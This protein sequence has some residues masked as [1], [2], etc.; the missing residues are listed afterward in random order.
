V[1]IRRNRPGIILLFFLSIT[2]S[3]CGGGGGPEAVS[4]PPQTGGA[5]PDAGGPDSGGDADDDDSQADG[6]E[7]GEDSGEDSGGDAGE[8]PDTGPDLSKAGSAPDLDVWISSGFL[9][10]D[11]DGDG[12]E[13]ASDPRPDAGP[14]YADPVSARSL[15]IERAWSDVEGYTVED[16]AREGSVLNLRVRGI[17]LDDA[18]PVW[19]AFR[20]GDGLRAAKAE[21]IANGLLEVIPA[22]GAT[23]AHV[24]A[25]SVRGP[26][27]EMQ[28]LQRTAPLLFPVEGTVIA[29]SQIE[30]QGL[31]LDHITAVALAGE[32]LQIGERSSRGITVRLPETGQGNRVVARSATT[33]SNGIEMDLRHEVT[34][35]VAPELALA[36]GESLLFWTEGRQHRLRHGEEL[37]L[38]AP[39]WKPLSLT[40][41]IAA[42]DTVRS[43]GRLKAT[44]LPGAGSLEVSARSTLLARLVALRDNLLDSDPGTWQGIR[45]A[46]EPALTTAAASDYLGTLA[47]HA[48]GRGPAPDDRLVNAVIQAWQPSADRATA[49]AKAGDAPTN[50]SSAKPTTSW[51]GDLDDIVTSTVTY[52]GEGPIDKDEAGTEAGERYPDETETIGNAYSQIIILQHGDDTLERLS[53]TGPQGCDYSPDENGWASLRNQSADVYRRLWRSDLCIQ[54]DGLVFASAAV[55]QPAFG[56]A[57]QIFDQAASASGPD[58]LPDEM[59]RRHTRPT[60]ADS[61]YQLK[62]GG[63]YLKSDDNSPLCHMEQCYIEVITSGYGAYY[64]VSLTPSQQ[65]IVKFLRQRMWVER[66][67]PWMLG[68]AGIGVDE[69][70]VNCLRDDLLDSREFTDAAD[71]LFARIRRD[72]DKILANPLDELADAIDATL[73]PWARKY[74]K[75]ELGTDFID[76]AVKSADAVAAGVIE[77]RI[78]DKL[79]ELPGLALFSEIFSF[80]RNLGSAVLT[81]EKFV[82]RVQPVAEITGITPKTI[83]LYESD[84]SLGILGDWLAQTDPNASTPC[85]GDGW[86]PELVVRD[87]FGQ[88]AVVPLDETN[89]E[90]GPSACGPVCKILEIP[91]SQLASPLQELASG[92]IR[93]EL[94]VADGSFLSYPGGKLRIPV[95]GDEMRL[96]TKAKIIGFSKPLAKPGEQLTIIGSN[97]GVF[98]DLADWRLERD[99]GFGGDFGLDVIEPASG[100]D[101]GP[102]VRLPAGIPEGDYKVVVEPDADAQISESLTGDTV[103]L[104]VGQPLPFIAAAD[105]GITR[106]DRMRIELLDSSGSVVMAERPLRQLAWDLPTNEVNPVGPGKYVFGEAWNDLPGEDGEPALVSAKVQRVRVTCAGSGSDGACTYAIRSLRDGFCLSRDSEP[107]PAVAGKLE[108]GQDETY[109]LAV[110]LYDFDGTSLGQ[111]TCQEAF[112]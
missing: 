90:P 77:E 48:A 53:W 82:F 9:V 25:G 1:M 15:F 72:E 111:Q 112:L 56:E 110:V 71:D 75:G 18:T 50:A 95:P 7:A 99:D 8:D 101:T 17:A 16:V 6:G 51:N 104:V 49:T 96:S 109:R 108:E 102:T 83:D 54:I 22:P 55:V 41:D 87:R 106:D 23:Q 45:A 70:V 29:G 47:E 69:N 4:T 92:P 10:S 63:Y 68:L 43:S 13:D 105:Q 79:P 84:E 24:I 14:V 61:E 2:L 66:L 32:P 81:P 3:A 42:G 39:A 97:L 57:R 19:V 5:P 107:I 73:G 26:A 20:T 46:L 35:R 78:S 62:E 58:S 103:L 28:T 36:Q 33:T 89:I 11:A 94:A 85:G 91:Y 30:L 44:I 76:C 67:I 98:G 93:V 34:L 21:V 64:T 12:I 74:V 27:R 60:F 59:V 65:E 38:Q 100:P 86:C 37:R 40:F 31:N 52:L 80:V 88:T